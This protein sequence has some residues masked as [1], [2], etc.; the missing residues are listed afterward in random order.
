MRIDIPPGER[1]VAMTTH[2]DFVLVITDQ[3]TIFEIKRDELGY[4]WVIR[5]IS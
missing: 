1:V 4:D 5:K 2:R 3:G